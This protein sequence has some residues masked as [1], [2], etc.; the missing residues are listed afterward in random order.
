MPVEAS[1]QGDAPVYVYFQFQE[2]WTIKE[3]RDAN[4]IA[5]AWVRNLDY[6][7]DAI[8][9]FGDS[10][11]LPSY[12]I[13]EGLDGLRRSQQL[14]NQGKTIV[15]TRSIFVRRIVQVIARLAP[16]AGMS[17][18]RDVEEARAVVARNWEK[19]TRDR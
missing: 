10:S 6:D 14:P 3:F 15:V 12:A 17:I 4:A 7:V 2:P 19:Q 8:F 1:F 5:G 18:C 13:S 16:T 9:D 11:V